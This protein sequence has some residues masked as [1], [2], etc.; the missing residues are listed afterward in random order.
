MAVGQ[1]SSMLDLVRRTCDGARGMPD[2]DGVYEPDPERVR[3]WQE[4]EAEEYGGELRYVNL[5]PQEVLRRL[6]AE[7]DPGE[8][9]ALRTAEEYWQKAGGYAVSG[10]TEAGSVFRGEPREAIHATSMQELA[11]AV[12]PVEHVTVVGEL[13][14]GGISKMSEPSTPDNYVDRGTIDWDLLLGCGQAPEPVGDDDWF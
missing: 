14:A 1:R 10:W 2:F 13:G 7:S 8:I 11:Q 3:E 12:T 5:G 4:R 9:A 6:G